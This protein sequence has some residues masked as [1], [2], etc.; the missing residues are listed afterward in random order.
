MNRAKKVIFVL[1]RQEKNRII[2][3]YK[4]GAIPGKNS[5]N[6]T[7]KKTMNNEIN[8]ACAQA[9]LD[10]IAELVEKIRPLAEVGE[11]VVI[12]P[13]AMAAIEEIQ[14]MV[15]PTDDFDDIFFD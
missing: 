7:R 15:D 13:E 8:N 12:S 6:T 11:V 14:A 2:A 3:L 1:T 10:R 5:N 9:A 4:S